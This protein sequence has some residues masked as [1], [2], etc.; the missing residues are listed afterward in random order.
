MSIILPDDGRV[1]VWM[2]SQDSTRDSKTSIHLTMK[3]SSLFV[4]HHNTAS[5]DSPITILSISLWNTAIGA[6]LI[7]SKDKR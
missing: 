3:V 1:A 6:G 7:K 4:P 5:S 2:K